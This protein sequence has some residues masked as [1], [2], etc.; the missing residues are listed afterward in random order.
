MTLLIS[1]KDSEDRTVEAVSSKIGF[2]KIEIKNSQFLV[3]GVPV[4]L[5]GV[6]LHDHDP[7]TGHVVDEELT[8]LDLKIMKEHNLNAIRCSHYPKNDFFYRLCDEYGFYVIDEANIEI[9]GMGATNQGLDNNEK[10]KA[11]HPAYRPEWKAMHLDRTI[12][13]FERDKNFTSIVTW[14][15][16]NEAGNGQNFVATYNWLKENDK[17]RPVQYEG[18]TQYDNTDIQAPMYTRIPGLIKYAENNPKRPF[19]LCEYAHAMGN[20]VGNLQDYWDVI[21]KYDVLQGGF[22]WDWVDQGL[23]ATTPD[24]TPYFGYGGDFGAQYLQNDRNFCL[25]G[26]VDPDRKLHPSIL[27]VKKVYQYI[28]FKEFNLATRSLTIYNGYDF[29]NLDDYYYTWQLLGDGLVEGS[30]SIPAMDIP[31]RQSK[32]IKLENLPSLQSGKE[33]FLHIQAKLK[34]DRPLLKAGHVVAEQDFP[35]NEF[36]ANKFEPGE[37]ALKLTKSNDDLTIN[38]NQFTLKL[39]INSGMLYHLDYGAGNILKSPVQ[40]N[41]WRAVTDNDFGFNMPKRF[42]VWKNA[43]QNQTLSNISIFNS[44][45]KER[46]ANIGQVKDFE[47][48]EVEIRTEFM[49]KDVDA[50]IVITY[51][52][53]GEGQILVANELK[54]VDEGTANIPRL[55]NNFVLDNTYNQVNWYG[56]GPHENYQ[57]RKTSALVRHYQRPVEELY[58]PYIRPQENGNRSDIRWVSFLD[59]TGKGIKVSAQNHLLNFS[60][61]HQL[62]S[63][64]DEGD[65]K[66]QRHDFDIPKRDIVNVNIDYLQMGVGG[67]NSWGNMPMGEYM[68]KAKDYS[69]NFMIEP[70]R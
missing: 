15:L 67:D 16:G 53:N 41:F 63:D 65:K 30:G 56:R 62:N 40:A 22:I 10:R 54:G 68:I 2:R 59:K 50:S 19:I 35:L 36:V 31:S 14:S 11:A 17:S 46:M 42:G 37:I 18:A 38:G 6:N 26:L 3:N 64:F 60:A 49:L 28:K 52:I 48:K 27:E 1:L 5:K 13:M 23:A 55:G 34:S 21:E 51:T 24:G 57:D 69:Y 4:Y 8:L 47:A 32:V 9:H 43:T 66:I 25:N 58:F 61:H 39:D 20:S 70:V 45:Q 29:E 7:V 33:Y 12:R 44:E